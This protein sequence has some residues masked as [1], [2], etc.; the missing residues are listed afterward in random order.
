MHYALDYS[1][2]LFFARIETASLNGHSV[3]YF[4]YEAY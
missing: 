2:V 4:L 1:F 3:N